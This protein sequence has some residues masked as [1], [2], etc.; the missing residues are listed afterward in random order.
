[1]I[2]NELYSLSRFDL[3]INKDYPSIYRKGLSK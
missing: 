2:A 1:L 3:Y